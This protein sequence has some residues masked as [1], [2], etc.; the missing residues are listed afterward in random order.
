MPGGS[1][2]ALTPSET[3]CRGGR[4]RPAGR[5]PIGDSVAICLRRSEWDP[6]RPTKVLHLSRTACAVSTP[7]RGPERETP[8][9]GL[10]S[11]FW[12][13]RPPTSPKRM[14]GA[15]SRTPGRAPTPRTGRTSRLEA[16]LAGG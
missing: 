3:H 4:R 16:R 9:F 1:A 8:R 2:S 11:V 6:S 15:R 12:L 5:Q 13:Y 10:L 14:G 7:E